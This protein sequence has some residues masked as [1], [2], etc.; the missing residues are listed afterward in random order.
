M[1]LACGLAFKQPFGFYAIARE[2]IF[3]LYR[4]KQRHQH[5]LLS[6]REDVS[7]RT[8]E[9][10]DARRYYFYVVSQWANNNNTFFIVS[11]ASERASDDHGVSRRASQCTSYRDER[12]ILFSFAREATHF[13]HCIA[14]SDGD[15]CIFMSYPKRRWLSIHPL[16]LFSICIVGV[17]HLS[18]TILLILQHLALDPRENKML[19]F[20]F[21]YILQLLHL[22]TTHQKISTITWKSTWIEHIYLSAE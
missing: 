21:L 14:R 7:S 11:H 6:H 9:R 4:E 8:R 19:A 5:F 10:Y 15:E 22:G 17:L 1:S 12:T 18:P 3:L 16:F 20:V 2:S 13:A